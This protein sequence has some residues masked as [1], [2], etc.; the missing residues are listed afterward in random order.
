MASNS[1]PSLDS[2]VPLVMI[3]NNVTNHSTEDVPC[4]E[5]KALG[6]NKKKILV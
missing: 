3:D 1:R 5:P 6:K 4:E 2:L